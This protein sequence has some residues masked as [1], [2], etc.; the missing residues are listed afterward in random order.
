MQKIFPLFILISTLF[1]LSSFC[2]AQPET[3]FETLRTSSQPMMNLEKGWNN[4]PRLARTRCWWWWLN[5]NVTKQRIKYDLKE[6][7]EKG[8]GGAN[9]IDAGGANQW[10]NEQV[11]HGP[12]FA[13]EEW[14]ELFVYALKEAARLDLEL[15]FN[16]MSGWNLGG[17]NVTVENA[18]KTLTWSEATITGGKKIRKK[19]ETPS[20]R[21]GFYRDTVTV[22]FPVGEDESGQYFSIK[23]SS[24]QPGYKSELAVDEDE[25]TFWVSGGKDPGEGPQPGNTEWIQLQ[26]KKEVTA[27]SITIIPRDGY[28]PKQAELQIKSDNKWKTVSEF[29]SPRHGSQTVTFEPCKSSRFRFTISDAY[30]PYHPDQPRNVQIEELRLYNGDEDIIARQRSAG[31]I[32]NFRQKAYYEMAGHFTAPETWYLLETSQQDSES[33][34]CKSSQIRDISDKVDDNGVLTW[35]AP[36]GNWKVLRFGYTFNGAYVSTHSEGWSGMAIDYLDKDAFTDYW[37]RVMEPIL[38]A[39][40]PYVGESLRFLHTDSWEL[41]AVNWT[42]GMREHF[43]RLR[44]YD[45]VNYMPA[46]AGY[47]VDS[48]EVSTRFLNDFRRTIADLIAENNYEVFAEYAH[49]YGLGIHPE[50]GGPH[51]APVDALRNL[52]ISDI[53]MGEFWAR[54]KTHRVEDPERLFTK[55]ASSAAHI[56]GKRITLAEAFTTIG[57]QWEKDPEMLKPVFDRVACEGLNLTMWHTFD[58]SPDKMGIPGQAYFAGTHLNPNVTWWEQADA[59]ISYLNRSHFLLQQG[60]P[61]SDVVHYYGENIPAF[62]RLKRDDPAGVLPGYDYDVIDKRAL[63]TRTSVDE[64]GNIVLPDGVSYRIL[65]LTRY[66]A[67][68]LPALEHIAEL[69]K[70]GATV[71]GEKLEKPYSLTGYPESD[72]KFKALADKLWEDEDGNSRNKYGEGLVVWGRSASEVLQSEGV[73]PDFTWSGGDEKTFLD[74]FHRTLENAEIYF[75]VNRNERQE[76]ARASFRVTGRQPEIWQPVS[77]EIRTAEAFRQQDGRT[78]VPLKLPANGSMFVVFREKIDPDASGSA[79]Y[80]FADY[81]PVKKIRGSWRVDFDPKLGGPSQTVE[82]D[83]LIDWSNHSREAIRYYSGEAVYSKAVN[84]PESVISEDRNPALD[85]GE[86]KNLA[87]VTLNGENLGVVWTHPYRIDISGAAKSGK[88]NLEIKVVN[89]WPNRLI[90]D[91]SKPPE[92]RIT[93]ANITKF[94]SD[95]RLLPSGLLG[96]VKILLESKEN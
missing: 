29:N 47:V 6:M 5:G 42:K 26:F 93:N 24:S 50:S 46:L 43:K 2:T 55:Q 27:D 81:Q 89:L 65:S 56:Y 13:S 33:V 15:G 62:V 14:K 11:P 38:R 3:I 68:S 18:A 86:V 88:N 72:K 31:R 91:A 90:G 61:V 45:M 37:R 28:G 21:K 44:D 71:V 51:A 57:P 77:G 66:D 32:E 67:I 7:K 69:V 78:I 63:L 23:A 96:P 9:I 74:Y 16:I 85:L 48:R 17:P 19:L 60:L 20:H 36:V 12:D 8:Y 53:P 82:F 73:Q 39:A 94:D 41:G 30:D 84:I 1:C 80:N 58:C 54:S 59:F 4:P 40:E 49:K 10:G 95:S 76:R 35:D 25:S 22:A 92:Q 52:G 70:A 83:E 75:V 79:E 34:S 87:E 64:E